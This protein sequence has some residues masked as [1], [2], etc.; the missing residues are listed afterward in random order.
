VVLRLLVAQRL[1]DADGLPN[2]DRQ[3]IYEPRELAAS[4]VLDKLAAVDWW[5]NPIDTSAERVLRVFVDHYNGHPPPRALDLTPPDQDRQTLR[6]AT[7][8]GPA[9]V[10][11]RDRLGGLIHEYNLAA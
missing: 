3:G 10:E 2:A 6:L 7:S 9:P 5:S 4:N 11:R 8:S 1:A